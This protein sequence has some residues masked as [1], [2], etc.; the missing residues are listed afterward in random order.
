MRGKAARIVL[1]GLI[2]AQM[3]MVAL[4]ADPIAKPATAADYAKLAKLP[5]WSGVWQP[6]WSKLFASRGAANATPSLTPAAA[7]AVADF[8]AAKAKGENLQTQL[9]NCV[10]PGMPQI[11]RMPYPIEFLVTPAVVAIVIETESQIRHVYVDGRPLPDDPDPY[12]NGWSVGRWEGDTLVVDTIGLNT[13]A[14]LME[15]IHPT[16]KTRIR[17]RIRLTARDVL[18]IETTIIDPDIFVTPLTTENVYQRRRDW[19]IK[20]YVCQ[21]NNHDAADEQGRPSFRLDDKK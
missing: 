16:E 15:G 10:P 7:K 19:Q 8:N 2:L 14:S 18:T 13:K 6:D 20:E 12:F 3:P 9:A 5:D 1:A 11:M 17:E 4:A 21:E